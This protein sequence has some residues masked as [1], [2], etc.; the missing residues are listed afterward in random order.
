M[1]TVLAGAEAVV[2]PSLY[3]GFGLPVLE[4]FAAGVP[5]VAAATSS[6]PEVAGG[7]AILT[8]PTGPRIAEGL[9]AATSADAAVTD[10]VRRGRDR[11]RSYT[12]ERSAREHAR[13]WTSLF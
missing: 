2:V 3:E 11:A 4:A 5:V 12:W 8:A 9:I 13:I 1:P 10:L 6:L 7:C